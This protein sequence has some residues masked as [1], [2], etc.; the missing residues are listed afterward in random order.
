MKRQGG[1][2]LI[3]LVVVIVIL[4]ILAVT[5]APRFLNLQDD[6]KESALQGLAGAMN[7]ASGIVFGKAA[8]E[9]QETSS[10]AVDVEDVETIWGYPTATSE[11]IA[12]AIDMDGFV[13]MAN[14]GNTAGAVVDYGFEGYTTQCVRYTAA[15]SAAQATARVVDGV[16]EGNTTVCQ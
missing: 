10:T 16:S 4:G 15:T 14:G 1:F 2:T 11:G 3:E 5:A 13:Y 9:G 12:A 8:I 7:G 6:A